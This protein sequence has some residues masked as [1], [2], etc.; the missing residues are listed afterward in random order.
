MSCPSMRIVPSV[1]SYIR[2]TSFRIVLFPEPFEPMMTCWG[3]DKTRF[4]PEYI[5]STNIR[6]ADHALL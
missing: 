2:A 5:L 4:V 3:E 1:G 6:R